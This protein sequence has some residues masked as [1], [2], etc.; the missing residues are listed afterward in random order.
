MAFPTPALALRHLV[1][2][3]V[4]S[5]RA[6]I[7][8]YWRQTHRV[9]FTPTLNAIARSAHYQAHRTKFAPT[10]AS[11]AEFHRDD[12]LDG[13]FTWLDDLD[14]SFVWY[15]YKIWNLSP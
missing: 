8:E 14:S 5:W 9:R 4:Q 1:G 13:F 11:I 12:W 15:V 6:L 3:L 7:H 2:D 10:L